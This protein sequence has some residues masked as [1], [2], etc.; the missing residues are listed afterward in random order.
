MSTQPKSQTASAK[1]R[2]DAK[3]IQRKAFEL[4]RLVSLCG[5]KARVDGSTV[6]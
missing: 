2:L 5:K 4:D 6:D 1:T 3:D